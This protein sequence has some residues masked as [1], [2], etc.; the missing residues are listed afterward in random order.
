MKKLAIYLFVLFAF[1]ITS[2]W[3]ADPIEVS[4]EYYRSLFENDVVRVLEM[5]L[6]SGAEDKMHVHPVETVYFVKGGTLH[7][8]L[9]GG[10]HVEKT[11]SDGEVM[12]H[13]AWEHRVKNVGSTEVIA[14]IVEQQNNAKQFGHDHL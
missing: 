8:T 13:E 4:P 3:A 2:A 12:F 10:A 7:I 11:I 14:V 6:P 1:S 9:P 5:R